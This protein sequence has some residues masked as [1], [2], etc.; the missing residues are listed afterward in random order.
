[1]N[2]TALELYRE[3]YHLHYEKG[4]LEQACQRYRKIVQTFPHSREASYSILQLEKI[5]V[6]SEHSE[7]VHRTAPIGTTVLFVVLAAALLATGA[8]GVWQW[9]EMTN[10]MKELSLSLAAT[11]SF[12]S[13]NQENALGSMEKLF[14][15]NPANSTTANILSK[16]LSSSGNFTLASAVLSTHLAA[17]GD[18]AAVAKEQRRIAFLRRTQEMERSA[19]PETVK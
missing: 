9:W 18:T 12:A 10:A 15:R 1:M 17:G 11:A 5:A 2:S 7:R 8:T 16:M 6:P 14:K 13:G 19:P 4:D 3:A